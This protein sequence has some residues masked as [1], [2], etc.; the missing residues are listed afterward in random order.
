MSHSPFRVEPGK[1]VDLSKWPTDD[2]G[3]FKDKSQAKPATKKNLKRLIELQELLYASSSHAVLIVLQAMDAGGKDGAIDH[4]FS[5]VNP[6]GCNVTSFKVPTHLELSHDY[7]W[8]YHQAC[9]RKGM[10]EI[11]NRSHYE[12]VLVERVKNLVS[13]DIWS[14]RYDQINDFE[15]M[16]TTEN[17]L[18]LKFFLHISKDEQKKRLQARL[19]DKSKHWKFD[20]NDLATRK[21]WDDYTEAFEDALRYC[22]TDRAPWYVVPADHKWFRNWVISDTIVRAMEKLSMKYPPA[23]TGLDKI[24]IH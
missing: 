24:K 21:Q 13:K 20:A 1:K 2:T 3:P 14:T 15:R 18:V 8:R 19:D 16:L 4:V 10:M 22:S 23:P 11:F 7:M 12:S 5:G 9:P 6:Q 17:T